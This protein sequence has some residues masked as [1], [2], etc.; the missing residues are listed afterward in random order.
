M[1]EVKT[2][3]IIKE[4]FYNAT[5]QSLLSKF[6]FSTTPSPLKNTLKKML[7]LSFALMTYNRKVLF[8]LF[9]FFLHL[10][11]RAVLRSQSC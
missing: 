11:D 9:F 10:V 5:A 6:N 7:L 3:Q 4:I 1:I 2:L 8:F